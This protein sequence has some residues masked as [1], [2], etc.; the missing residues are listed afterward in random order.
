MKSQLLWFTA[1]IL[2]SL[3]CSVFTGVAAPLPPTAIPKVS[4]FVAEE[5]NAGSHTYWMSPNENGCEA[6]D[7]LK[8]AQ[9]REK[10]FTFAPDFS[11]VTYGGRSYLRVG[12]HRYESINESEKPLVLTFSEHGYVLHVYHPGDDPKANGSCLTFSFTLAD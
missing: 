10:T 7:D 9:Y 2:L 11:A 3:A 4:P 5:A 12:E 8:I 1:I 6:S